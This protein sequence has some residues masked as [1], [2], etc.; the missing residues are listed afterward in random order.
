MPSW[1]HLNISVPSIE[2]VEGL[3]RLDDKNGKRKLVVINDLISECVN[4]KRLVSLFSKKSPDR[5]CGAIFIVQ[6]VS[7]Q[8]KEM[9]NI[10]QKLSLY[11]L[12]LKILGMLVS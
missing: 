7:V 5:N 6:N 3:Q 2:F 1:V 9:R 10:T 4:D 11:G 8:G 12:F